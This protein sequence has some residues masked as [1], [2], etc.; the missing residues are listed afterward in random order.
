MNTIEKLTD[1]LEREYLHWK[2]SPPT[3]TDVVDI[4]NL[5]AFDRDRL[6]QLL[7]RQECRFELPFKVF[8]EQF[9]QWHSDKEE[10]GGFEY[11]RQIWCVS[12]VKNVD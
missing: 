10:I 3:T 4:P 6:S 11:V 9:E 12:W 2:Q 8:R 1:D 5:K 7:A